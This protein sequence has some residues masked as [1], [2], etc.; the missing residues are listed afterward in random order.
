[1]TRRGPRVRRR[2]GSG[3]NRFVLLGD[4]DHTGGCGAVGIRQ[5]QRQGVV[6]ID[7]TIV[8]TLIVPATMKL[9]GERNWWA[10]A[11]LRRFHHRFGLYEAP[12]AT[13]HAIDLDAVL[14]GAV[15]DI[16]PDREAEPVGTDA[17]IMER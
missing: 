10:P 9:L 11:P 3:S 2:R 14:T 16:E 7:A 12:P 15:D 1:M 17:G 4:A 6:L 5:L 13:P 8:R